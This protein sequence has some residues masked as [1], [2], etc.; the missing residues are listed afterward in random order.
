MKSTPNSFHKKYM[1]S[2]SQYYFCVLI[3]LSLLLT[4][5]SLRA[6][7][8]DTNKKAT[9]TEIKVDSNKATPVS[10]PYKYKVTDIHILNDP[11]DRSLEIGDKLVIQ[12][13][14]LNKDVT[15]KN[16][17]LYIN[18]IPIKHFEYISSNIPTKELFFKLSFNDSTKIFW[19][20]HLSVYKQ[21]N[22][23]IDITCAIENYPPFEVVT[24]EKTKVT[25]TAY[26][27]LNSLIFAS[28]EILIIFTLIYCIRKNLL[29]N[30]II[31]NCGNIKKLFS[32]EEYNKIIANFD[33]NKLPYS[34]GTTQIVL[35]FLII[36]S[37]YL[38]LFLLTENTPSLNTT[39]LTL[40]GIS[41][42]TAL[43]NS[44]MNTNNQLT[45][46]NTI[47]EYLLK[48][49]TFE[50]KIEILT[51]HLKTVTDPVLI[52]SK[53]VELIENKTKLKILEGEI[54]DLADNL[55]SQPRK[56]FLID[57]VSDSSGI[58]FAR[59][60]IAAWTLVL[61]VIFVFKVWYT[62]N[63]PEFEVT[64]LTLMGISSGTFLTFKFPENKIKN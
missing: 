19:N 29:A 2:I 44:F 32:D 58:S 10:N 5:G 7:P 31:K 25:F 53:K 9:P 1:L 39:V 38:Y 17:I 13:D 51:E 22:Q 56:S 43:G 23:P 59:F 14:S 21:N 24:S 8:A 63:M 12:L 37:A 15:S 52:E 11:N 46:S 20:E 18:K 42:A 48:K 6:E 55:K 4:I 62:M 33:S 50:G 35:W 27:T 3:A 57:L 41:T 26:N 16:L 61:G 34:L 54:Q 30:P 47:N 28:I 45:I 40:L 49:E 60:Q 64:L 36:I